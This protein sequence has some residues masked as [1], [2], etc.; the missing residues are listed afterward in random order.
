MFIPPSLST[1]PG[2]REGPNVKWKVKPLLNGLEMFVSTKALNALATLAK[3]D[4]SLHTKRTLVAHS[5]AHE[6]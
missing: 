2:H 4:I 1:F 6:E 5:A 3:L